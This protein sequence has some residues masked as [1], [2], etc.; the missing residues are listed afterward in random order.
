MHDIP[1]DLIWHSHLMLILCYDIAIVNRL[2]NIYGVSNV[3]TNNYYNSIGTYTGL[4]VF[5]LKI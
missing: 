3:F 2:V 4:K 1:I 5:L